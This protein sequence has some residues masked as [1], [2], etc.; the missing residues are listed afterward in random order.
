MD[1]L[2]MEDDGTAARTREI[3]VTGR[4]V[5]AAVVDLTLVF[6][7]SSL[8]SGN[9]SNVSATVGAS[10]FIGLL[11]GV[12]YFISLEGSRS[13]TIGKM[14]AGIEVINQTTGET[15]GYGKATM[16]T[17]LRVIDGIF[18]Y[19]VGFIV[20][21]ISDR[22]QRLGDMAAGTLVVRK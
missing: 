14:A 12:I 4:R 17:V 16:R 20:V 21:L 1:S 13:Q 6:F 22:R 2:L 15:P 18:F 10:G 5:A 9:I 8:L 19:L 7:V 3:Y 11:I